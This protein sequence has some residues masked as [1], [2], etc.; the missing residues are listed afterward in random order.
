LFFAILS[1]LSLP[2]YAWS[3]HHIWIL[4]WAILIVNLVSLIF[5]L[6][7]RIR[8]ILFIILLLLSFMITFIHSPLRRLLPAGKPQV[9]QT[10]H[11]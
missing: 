7:R 10:I 5:L 9:T 2:F 1:F 3:V 11:P 8:N 6:I 4:I